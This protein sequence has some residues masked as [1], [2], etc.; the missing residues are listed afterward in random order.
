MIT[1]RPELK[2]IIN[3][4]RR[5]TFQAYQVLRRVFSKPSFNAEQLTVVWQTINA[6]YGCSYCVPAHT[7]IAGLMNID[8][9]LSETLINREAM[10][11][12]K[13]K[14]PLAWQD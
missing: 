11:T 14:M 7:A 13:L 2:F 1:Q 5:N 3:I 9:A 6:E 12:V 10:P 4:L 8:A